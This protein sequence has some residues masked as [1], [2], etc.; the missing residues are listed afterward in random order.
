[1]KKK[2]REKQSKE[3][4]SIFK[5]IK[6]SILLLFLLFLIIFIIFFIY[7]G[8][9]DIEKDNTIIATKVLVTENGQEQKIKYTIKIRNYEIESAIKEIQYEE[10]I[11]AKVEYERYETINI[12]ERKGIDLKIKGKKIILNMPEKELRE[13]LEYTKRKL[14]ITTKSGEE[15]KI[16]EQDEIKRCLL[17]QGYKIK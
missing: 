16:L 3:K 6:K 1:M 7:C 13:D 17:N 12:A 5:T 2:K 4:K 15:K 9:I 10:K 8:F 14:I 11:I